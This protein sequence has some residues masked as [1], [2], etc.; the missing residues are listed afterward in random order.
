MSVNNRIRIA[1]CD[2]VKKDCIEIVGLTKKILGR[3]NISHSIS[4]YES[5]KELLSDIQKGVDFQLLLLDVLMDEMDGMELAK[6]LRRQNNKAAIIFVSIN[7]EMA[8]RGYEVSAARYLEK[9]LNEE[10]LKEALL[11]C[12][13]EIQ[14]KKE[15]LLPT[16]QGQCRISISDI[17]YVEAFERGSKFVL[18]NESIECR[19][20]FGDVEAL[21]PKPRFLLCHRAYIVN[22]DHVKY[23]RNYEFELNNG[24]IISIGKGRYAEAHKAFVNY[25]TD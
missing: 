13:K 23:I 17:Q 7:R 3:A 22:L 14:I 15:I 21:L 10:K 5:A 16:V 1:V 19:L 6:E 18:A 12:Y 2:D 8:L 11:Y 24:T 20:K 9:P 25:I 4:A